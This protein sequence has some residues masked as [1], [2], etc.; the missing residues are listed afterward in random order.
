MEEQIING[1]LLIMALLSISVFSSMLLKKIHFPYTIGLVVIGLFLGLLSY[2]YGFFEIFKTPELSP[3]II[4]YLILPILIFEAAM[5]IDFAVLRRNIIPILLLAVF[6]LLISAFIIGIGVA[7]FTVLGFMGALVF[8]ALISATDPVAVIALFNEIG[9]P[10]RLVTLIDG[11]SIFNDATAI[12]LF[13]LVIVIASVSGAKVNLFKSGMDFTIILLG[14]VLV[15]FIIGAIGSFVNN[16]GKDNLL[17]QTTVSVI[18]AYLSFVVSDHFLHFSG[19]MSTL[20][21]GLVMRAGAEKT[22][23][24]SNIVTLEH[25]WEY[26]SFIANSIVFLLLGITE[27]HIFR[28]SE[29]ISGLLKMTF[30][31]IPIVLFARLACIYILIPLYNFI[32]KKDDMKKIP[33]GYQAVL[34]WGGLRG[35]VPVALVL[36]IPM[37]FP[38][39]ILIIQFTFAFILF[40]LL[41]Q[42]TTIKWLMDKLNIRPEANE[43]GDRIT[44]KH[45][46]DF[47]CGRLAL[48]IMQS[49]RDMFDDEAYFIRD[50]STVDGAAYLMQSGKVMLFIEQ[51]HNKIIL[52]TE[53]ANVSYF[54]RVLYETL[55]SLNQAVE[56]IKDAADLKKMKNLI[57]DS[58]DDQQKI[59]FNIM[60]YL[61]TEQMK[62]NVNANK[63]DDIIFELLQYLVKSGDIKKDDFEGILRCVTE[64]E[65]SMTTGLGDGIAMPHARKCEF[66]KKLTVLI[67]TAPDGKDFDSIDGKPVNIFVLILSPIDA[68][69]PHVQVLATM[70]R[71][72]NNLENRKKIISSKNP[73]ELY[74]NI[75]EI[76]KN[77]K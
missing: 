49:L 33:W 3:G 29:N 53:H 66:V 57:N 70:G 11:E 21:A 64:R 16:F 32:N 65:A 59:H 31:V 23:K 5:N 45:E 7:S 4:L 58:K 63:K 60:K 72:F 25:F 39:R 48:L 54:K 12:V 35:A 20:A 47:K 34:F 18:M 27:Y 38:H 46:F 8:G 30:L 2:H 62:I 69:A 41:F 6:G 10:K 14:G 76:V 61:S 37:D 44:E 1:V 42:G 77:I 28:N 19:V 74:H 15:G 51:D 67:A 73:D 40:T 43:F 22:I 13:N 75:H 36:A 17:R 24:R 55:L 68:V 71:I 9:A 26:F 52:T 50:K 56:A